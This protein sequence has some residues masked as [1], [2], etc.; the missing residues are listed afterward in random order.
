VGAEYIV[1]ETDFPHADSTYPKSHEKIDPA[2]ATF[3][4]AEQRML[5]RE[6]AEYWYS[7]QAPTVPVLSSAAGIA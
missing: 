5:R 4:P 1:L 7:F 2:L 3:T 6:N